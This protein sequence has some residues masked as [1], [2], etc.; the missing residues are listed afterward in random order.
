M[1]QHPN[2]KPTPRG[3]GDHLAHRVRP[4]RRRGRPADERQP[5]DRQQFAFRSDERTTCACSQR[6]HRTPPLPLDSPD[7]LHSELAFPYETTKDRPEYPQTIAFNMDAGA[8]MLN[9]EVWFS[10]VAVT[11]QSR[12]TEA[13]VRRIHQLK[14]RLRKE[15]DSTES[16]ENVAQLIAVLTKTM[17]RD[18]CVSSRRWRVG[19]LASEGAKSS[20]TDAEAE[21]TRE[22]GGSEPQ[23]SSRGIAE[24]EQ[25]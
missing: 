19:A 23:G 5:P 11:K 18:D 14:E 16:I 12:E 21:R 3:R 2:A 20:S 8:I 4:R 7:D 22:S 6:F 13:S 15:P 9:K 1:P 25:R 24:K 10:E 17:G